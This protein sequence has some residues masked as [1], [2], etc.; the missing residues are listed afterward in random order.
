MEIH[1]QYPEM[2][3]IPGCTQD[4]GKASPVSLAK[5]AFR[6]PFGGRNVAELREQSGRKL[7]TLSFTP[8]F[9]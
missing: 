8:S 9:N 2:M 4:P 6:S 1:S 3:S 7:F 5:G